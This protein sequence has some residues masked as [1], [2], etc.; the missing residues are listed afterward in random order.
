MCKTCNKN[1]KTL[2]QWQVIKEIKSR[3]KLYNDLIGLSVSKQLYFLRFIFGI[4]YQDSPTHTRHTLNAD[5]SAPSR[6]CFYVVTILHTPQHTNTHGHPRPDVNTRPHGMSIVGIKQRVPKSIQPLD[7][8]T[9]A[10]T[11]SKWWSRWKRQWFWRNKWWD[12]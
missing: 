11:K 7:N 12:T 2:C 10:Q 9:N 1:K 4:K 3:C 5:T 8:N 6:M